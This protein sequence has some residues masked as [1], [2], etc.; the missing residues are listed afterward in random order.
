MI[1]KWYSNIDFELKFDMDDV[2]R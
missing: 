2:A 1:R